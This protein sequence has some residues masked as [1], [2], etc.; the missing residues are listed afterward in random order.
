MIKKVKIFIKRY[1]Y[2]GCIRHIYYYINTAIFYKN[3]RLIRLP[4]EI[5]GASLINLGG[6]LTTGKNC[7]IEAFV[8]ESNY[9][10]K[11]IIISFGNDVILNDNV[12][13][14]AKYSIKI[15]NNVLIASKVFISDHN[16]GN[17]SGAYE[18]SS[19]LTPPNERELFGSSVVIEDNV[20]L[21]EFTS[22]LPGV[23][24]G[25][26]CIIGAMSVVTKSIPAYSMAVG[27]PAK[28]IKAY[29]L[30]EKKWEN[31]K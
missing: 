10:N 6:K 4:I 20:W 21:G 29:N 18:Q 15:G 17:Y 31:V 9:L 22:V 5:R 27:S 19:P 16:H 3:A 12:H 25:K 1:G 24:I 26:G 14:A 2:I 8:D 28:V 23:T 30:F 11:E 13:I 7:R